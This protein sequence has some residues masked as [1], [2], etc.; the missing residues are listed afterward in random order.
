MSLAASLRFGVLH[1]DFVKGCTIP[2]VTHTHTHTHA[3][4]LQEFFLATVLGYKV[5]ARDLG[6]IRVS[7]LGFRVLGVGFGV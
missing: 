6:L 3:G 7:A 4:S 2:R 1:S 5:W